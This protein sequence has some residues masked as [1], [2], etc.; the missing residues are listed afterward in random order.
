[1]PELTPALQALHFNT[2]YHGV[3]CYVLSASCYYKME[4][5]PKAIANCNAVL[6]TAP[7]NIKANKIKMLSC[8]HVGEYEQALRCAEVVLCLKDK[9]SCHGRT[10]QEKQLLMV[11]T[12]YDALKLK[13]GLSNHKLGKDDASCESSDGNER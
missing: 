7:S 11:Q 8:E 5:Y 4:Q 10:P 12:H 1:M 2:Y 9:Y 13:L 3:S 6:A